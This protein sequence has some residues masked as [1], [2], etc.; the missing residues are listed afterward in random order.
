MSDSI[1]KRWQ[2]NTCLLYAEHDCCLDRVFAHALNTVKR[3][4]RTGSG[5]PPPAARLKLYG[6]YK[7][8]MEGDVEGVMNRPDGKGA[9]AEAEMAKWYSSHNFHRFFTCCTIPWHRDFVAEAI[10]L[11]D[12]AFCRDAWAEHHGLGRTEAKRYYINT[13]LQTMHE[14]ASDTAESRELISELEFVWEQVKSNSLP[15]SSSSRHRGFGVGSN[16]LQNLKPSYATFP[17]QSTEVS[18]NSGLR[19]LRPVSERD[20]G[21]E[22]DSDNIDLEP[23]ALRERGQV[24]HVRDRRWRRRIEETLIRVTAE[25]A[26]LRKQVETNRQS[27]ALHRDGLWRWFTWFLGFAIKHV[28]IDAV[29]LTLFMIWS[30]MKYDGSLGQQLRTILQIVRNQAD[31]LQ[32]QNLRRLITFTSKTTV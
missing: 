15:S 13:L 24:S 3:I 16:Q 19:L 21:E 27:R 28:L 18:G 5:R 8:S 12:Y 4:P 17:G 25:I 1:G 31:T 30:K 22:G 7:Q 2:V 14:H 26:A 32:W 11:T 10:L 6:L 20:I 9:A 23:H 29:L